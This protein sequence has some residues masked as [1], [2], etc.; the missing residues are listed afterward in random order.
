MAIKRIPPMIKPIPIMDPVTPLPISPTIA[1]PVI[2]PV[3]ELIRIAAPI[4]ASIDPNALNIV[5]FI[6][7]KALID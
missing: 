1:K 4:T 6:V 5:L 3:N 2:L 7:K